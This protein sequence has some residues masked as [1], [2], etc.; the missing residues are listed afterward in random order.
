MVKE[1][2]TL[3][4]AGAGK[5]AGGCA[6]AG[7]AASAFPCGGL[8]PDEVLQIPPGLGRSDHPSGVDPA[9]FTVAATAS[10]HGPDAASDHCRDRLQLDR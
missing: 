7:C 3:V 9:A 5:T 6:V 10:P 4:K 1:I 2:E 8:R